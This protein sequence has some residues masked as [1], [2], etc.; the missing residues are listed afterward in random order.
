MSADV[1]LMRQSQPAYV[2]AAE[3]NLRWNF[4]LLTL[5]GATFAFAITLLSETTI[6]PAFVR[7]LTDVPFVFGLLA[8]T[9]AVGHFLPSLF[10]AHLASGRV[11]RK[12]LV[13]AVAVAERVGILAM[14]AAAM[15]VGVLPNADVLVLFFLAFA[16]YAVTTGLIGPAY[17]DFMAKSIVRWRGRFYGGVQLIG[18]LMG[19]GAATIAS[20]LLHE[21]PYP[22]GVQACFWLAFGLSFISLLFIANLREVP[23]PETIARV[24][25]RRL[26]GEVPDLLRTHETYRWFL[27]GRSIVALG[28]MGVGFVAVAGLQRGLSAA[29]AAAFAAVYLLAQSVGGLAWGLVGDR[30]GWKLVLEG[31]ASALALGMI[32]AIAATGFPAFGLAFGLLGI[33]NAGTNSSD[34]NLTYEVAPPRQ[35]S[36]YLG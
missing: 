28:T 23:Y 16:F 24:P 32:V 29:D 27:V 33:A 15:T 18:G 22:S 1:E 17:G 13:L 3:R 11:R 10:G 35:T 34:P 4:A 2:D 6:L 12:P 19:F 14:A 26:L 8:A 31:A 20:R 25:F 9:F 5:D 7:S 36:R 30:W 21:L